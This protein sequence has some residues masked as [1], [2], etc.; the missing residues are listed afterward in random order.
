MNTF[1]PLHFLVF[2]S[3]FSINPVGAADLQ[4]Q[5]EERLARHDLE[6]ALVLCQERLKV[7]PRD[8][9][10]LRIQARTLSMKALSQG[11]SPGTGHDHGHPHGEGGEAHPQPGASPASD[12]H[13]SG[14]E[15]HNNSHGHGSVEQTAQAHQLL[16][17]AERSLKAA[18]EVDPGCRECYL[19][20]AHLYRPL[21][22]D[23]EVLAVAEKA[24]EKD[25]P[26][27]A[28]PALTLMADGLA[29]EGRFHLAAGLYGALARANPTS[30][31]LRI[32]EGV[33]LARSGRPDEGLA[34]LEDVLKSGKLDLHA[35]KNVIQ[36]RILLRRFEEA[37]K[38]NEAILGAQPKNLEALFTQVLLLH[39]TGGGAAEQALRDFRQASK[40]QKLN[41]TLARA[42]DALA[43]A[44]AEK[45]APEV[46]G[47]LHAMADDFIQAQ[48]DAF[49]LLFTEIARHAGGETLKVWDQRLKIYERV[50]FPDQQ[51]EAFEECRKH[52]KEDPQLEIYY[53]QP[54][55]MLALGTVYF[56]DGLLDVAE[57]IWLRCQK[58]GYDDATMQLHLGRLAVESKDLAKARE[59]FTL[60]IERKEPAVEVLKAEKWL[61][62]LDHPE[63][64]R[65]GGE[66]TGR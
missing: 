54:K 58:L 16:E 10:A 44:A 17:E 24:L 56:H 19:D 11:A 8:P 38:A 5:V 55:S 48:H 33:C 22:R 12:D 28:T 65:P 9:I 45:V 20:L 27:H 64:H 53:A 1:R 31:S 32:S 46:V 52:A 30:S 21:G 14:G 29:G 37:K 41:P 36:T 23:K 7:E 42:L 60:A 62:W 3:L 25:P 51:F 66:G 50:K 15:G 2:V 43:G 49:A 47:R 57:K 63:T 4:Q 35:M 61:Y 40:D 34:A 59:H 26:P 39:A 18:L 13:H 6:G